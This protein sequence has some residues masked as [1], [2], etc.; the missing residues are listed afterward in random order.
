MKCALCWG[1][2]RI[3]PAVHLSR[4]RHQPLGSGPER[5]GAYHSPIAGA[6]H[7]FGRGG[8]PSP[9][10]QGDR[11]RC[12]PLSGAPGPQ[13]GPDPAFPSTP[14]TKLGGI[15]ANNASGIKLRHRPQ[16]L[17]H[18]ARHDPCCWPMAPCWRAVIPTAA[19]PWRPPDARA[20]GR[21][22]RPARRSA[23][24]RR[25]C[26]QNPPQYRLKNTTGYAIMPCSIGR[27]PIDI[28][29]HLMIGSRDPS[30]LSPRWCSIPC[31]NT[32]TRPSALL[33]FRDAEQPVWPLRA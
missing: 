6:Y 4:R 11:R 32:P 13:I 21:A 20:A 33:V 9:R 24:E 18:P 29:T 31:P 12:Q 15:A 30:A 27:D 19:P 10:N 17:S 23:G 7:A 2:P 14:A 26:R 1:V 8:N 28:P 25:A 16:Q 5:F 22:R 3:G